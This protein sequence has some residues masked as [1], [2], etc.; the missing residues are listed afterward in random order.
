MSQAFVSTGNN[1]YPYFTGWMMGRLHDT[2]AHSMFLMTLLSLPGGTVATRM[3]L[4][5]G[6]RRPGLKAQLCSWLAVTTGTYFTLPEP[7]FPYL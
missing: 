6:I 2:L 4:G 3:T 1:Y 5:C 7:Q